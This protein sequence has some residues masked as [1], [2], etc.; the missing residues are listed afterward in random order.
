MPEEPPEGVPDAIDF[1]A[2]AKHFK[3]PTCDDDE[4]FYAAANLALKDA[5]NLKAGWEAL[6]QV[7]ALASHL[8]DAPPP[9]GRNLWPDPATTSE[10]PYTC[11]L[12]PL[13]CVIV[14]P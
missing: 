13:P 12:I 7:H 11:G 4:D 10:S 9:R 5:S 14:L 8:L 2:A 3:P 6:M 1:F